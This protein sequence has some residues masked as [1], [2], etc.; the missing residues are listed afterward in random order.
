MTMDRTYWEQIAPDY[1][2]EIF[3]VLHN[4]KRELI[5][6]A[7]MKL[8]SPRKT[9]IDAGCAIGKWLPV[10]SPNFKKVI[11]ADISARNLDIA[12]KKY[13]AFK[14]VDYLR[15]DMSARNIKI[16]RADVV[17][18]INAILTSSVKKRDAFFSNISNCLNKNGFLVLVVPS[19]ESYLLT[20]IIQQRWKIDRKLFDETVRNK[21]GAMKYENMLQGN[22]EI[23]Q[24]FTKHYLK[25]ELELLL[26]KEGFSPGSFEKIEYSWDTE[27]VNPPGWLKDPKPWDWLF[28]AKKR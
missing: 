14:N 21:E 13:P 5:R 9:V 28:V 2:E 6:S 12:K 15:V 16:P 26:E 20:K 8:A 27:F 25:E 17:V 10:L 23:D 18:C 22:M 3:D 7:I 11:A 1:N 24:V 4:D 19:L